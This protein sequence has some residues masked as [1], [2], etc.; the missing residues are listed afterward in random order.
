MIAIHVPNGV[1]DREHLAFFAANGIS[2]TAVFDSGI[3][4][5]DILLEV[6]GWVTVLRIPENGIPQIEF[7]PVVDDSEGFGPISAGD[8]LAE[9]G[10]IGLTGIE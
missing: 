4:G 10:A 5:D 9:G 7:E 6:V 2:R 1:V 8:F 3:D